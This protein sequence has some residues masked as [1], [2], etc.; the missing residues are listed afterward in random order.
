MTSVSAP[1]GVGELLREW[2][3]RRRL[4][5][6]ELALQ[7]EVS[8]R[9]VSFVETGRATPSREM[10]L[11]LAEQLEV[12]LRERNQLLLAGG[13]AP[14]YAQAGLDSPELSSV[15]AAVREVLTAHE[16]NPAIVVDRHW[17]LVDANAA[18]GLFLDGVAT[19]LRTSPIN[20]MRL[21][22]HPQGAAPRI[23]NLAQWRAH[24]LGRLRREI[25]QTAD[26][27]LVR[28]YTEIRGYQP[29]LDTTNL[30]MPGAGEVVIPLRL[31]NGDQELVF[32]SMVAAF[33]T[34]LDITVDELALELFFPANSAT[35]EVLRSRST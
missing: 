10:I 9:H 24:L 29:D 5:Q 4:T 1:H 16:P 35:A 6:M 7:A 28:L 15:R 18:V 20:V 14:L 13:Y 33:G 26:P 11:H 19:E 25:T 31:R 22:L 30:E 27:E 32:F 2:R 8:T 3:E 12:P 21:S 17:N 23:I 34:P